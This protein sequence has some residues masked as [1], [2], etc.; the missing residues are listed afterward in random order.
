VTLLKEKTSGF[1]GRPL[2]SGVDLGC[3]RIQ[4]WVIDIVEDLEWI[5]APRP[6]HI[7][8]CL[9]TRRRVTRQARPVA[10]T[11]HE[12]SS[13]RVS[14][15]PAGWSGVLRGAAGTRVLICLDKEI[16]KDAC[17]HAVIVMPH[18]E[19]I[20]AFDVRDALVEEVCELLVGELAR[21]RP[22]SKLVFEGAAMALM[23]HLLRRCSGMDQ[24]PAR[25]ARGLTW[26][27]RERLLKA[28]RAD[29]PPVADLRELAAIAG[30]SRFHFSR[31]FKLSF[32][33]TPMQFLENERMS[34]A[35]A[36]LLEG[37]LSFSDIAM[38]LGYSEHSHFTRRF[39]ANTGMTPTDFARAA[40]RGDSTL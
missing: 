30:L 2:T 34:R 32:G 18:P 36:L 21:P 20:A 37:K 6:Q 10:A 9:I 19:L 7:I 15:L 25:A 11:A 28:L 22:G 33:V 4:A 27:S 14:F 26:K 35:K 24:L 39:K 23:A 29:I 3:G 17:K 40:R 38:Q 16:L 1:P 5:Y 8:V 13:G 12:R 31:Q